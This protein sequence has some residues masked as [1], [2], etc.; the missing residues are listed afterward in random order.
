MHMTGQFVITQSR[1]FDNWIKNLKKNYN[2]QLLKSV[3]NRGSSIQTGSSKDLF[4]SKES[5]LGFQIK[6]FYFWNISSC[7]V[8]THT[9]THKKKFRIYLVSRF[10]LKLFFWFGVVSFI[11]TFLA[12]F[13][14]NLFFFVLKSPESE[15]CN[16][17]FSYVLLCLST[18]FPFSSFFASQLHS[19]TKTTG[20]KK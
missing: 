15:C 6:N 14:F 9:H 20:Q 8:C 11:S 3:F 13:L 7:I 19:L 16:F 2:Y 17:F 18:S 1:N 10:T 5:I 4:F 12:T